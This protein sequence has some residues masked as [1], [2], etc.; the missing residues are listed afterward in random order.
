MAHR[1]RIG[2]NRNVRR[3]S[4]VNRLG[5][6]IANSSG[7][8]ENTNTEILE[9][10]S[11]QSHGYTSKSVIESLHCHQNRTKIFASVLVRLLKGQNISATLPSEFSM[12]RY[13]KVLFL[14]RRAYINN[15]AYPF[16]SI[17]LLA[18][19]V[20]PV[21]YLLTRKFVTPE[22]GWKCYD[23]PELLDQLLLKNKAYQRYDER[24]PTAVSLGPGQMDK[25]SEQFNLALSSTG[26]IPSGLF[27][28]MLEAMADKR[29]LDVDGQRGSSFEHLTHNDKVLEDGVF[30]DETMQ[31][32]GRKAP[33]KTIYCRNL[34]LMISNLDQ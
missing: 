32:K 20:L 14:E 33:K 16:T 10:S 28:A 13:L 27:N 7:R 34:G 21:I 25:M 4:I 29:F 31:K 1:Q 26:K 17:A 9:M 2:P 24:S 22:I 6:P 23:C 30:L 8:P 5:V 11:A 3:R 19:C 15:A 12:L 18:Y